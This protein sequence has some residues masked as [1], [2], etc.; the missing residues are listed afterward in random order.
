VGL[1]LRAQGD[2]TKYALK[3]VALNLDETRM[4]AD[5][6]FETGEVPA[7][8]FTLAI[9]QLDADRYLGSATDEKADAITPEVIALG[10][11]RLPK[12]RLRALRIDG[13][14]S[15]KTLRY[16]GA[17]L[18]DL[19]VALKAAAGKLAL[20][21]RARLYDGRYQ[22]EFLLDVNGEAP[23]LDSNTTLAKINLASLLADTVARDDLA[24]V[25][26]FEARLSMRGNT[27]TQQL[28]S[29]SGPA[30]FAITEGEI[31]GLDLPAV[32]RAAE[33]TLERKRPEIPPAGGSTRFRSVTG[34]LNVERG[35]VQNRDL[36][37]EGEGFQI[38][39]EGVLADLPRKRM[40]FAARLRVPPGTTEA[41]GHRY[42]LGDYEIPILCRG[43]LAV[44]SCT[45]DLVGLAG[46]AT[47]KALQK[48]VE[49]LIEEKAGGAEKAIKKLL[50][51]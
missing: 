19:D 42:N 35:V 26:N 3:D 49:K 37:M 14:A 50:E 39:G 12:A 17:K 41:Q 11:M 20:P 27:T 8:A 10:A 48:G 1:Q 33:I 47:G 2:A 4:T 44:K 38:A 45:P 22:G 36:L 28:A 24:G 31:K 29:L 34:S 43:P 40:D 9:D 16:A 5:F 15:C 25:L 32:L 6:L 18:S 7:V 23:T 46:R 21:V 51:F 13:Q 30:S